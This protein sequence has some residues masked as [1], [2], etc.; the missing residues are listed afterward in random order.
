MGRKRTH[1]TRKRY[2]EDT[3]RGKKFIPSQEVPV[4]T[5]HP[6]YWFTVNAYPYDEIAAL[7]FLV[8]PKKKKKLSVFELNKMELTAKALFDG[9]TVFV[10]ENKDRSVQYHDH[11]HITYPYDPNVPREDSQAMLLHDMDILDTKSRVRVLKA[12]RKIWGYE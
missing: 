3:E 11:A 2:T 12:V 10:N 8:S 6:E 9:A 7:H 1:S 5:G 4:L